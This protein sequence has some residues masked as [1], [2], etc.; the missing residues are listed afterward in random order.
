MYVGLRRRKYTSPL[1]MLIK[2]KIYGRT[3]EA[4]TRRTVD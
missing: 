4:G 3:K 2:L 1:G